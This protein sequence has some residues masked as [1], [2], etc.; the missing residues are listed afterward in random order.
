[1]GGLLP[2]GLPAPQCVSPYMPDACRF[3]E[4]HRAPSKPGIYIYVH[5]VPPPHRP[6]V[7]YASAESVIQ[8]TVGGAR[9]PAGN[10]S[11][12]S[13]LRNSESREEPQFPN[14]LP[15]PQT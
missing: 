15:G 8:Q 14:H 1:M 12:E 10:K 9:D 4:T 11:R 7:L 5:T 3:Q 6:T 13:T 2:W